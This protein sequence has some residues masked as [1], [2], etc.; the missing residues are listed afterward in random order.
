MRFVVTETEMRDEQTDALVVV[1]R[2]TMVQLHADG[3]AAVEVK[4]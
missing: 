3:Q 2:T 4:A 1:A